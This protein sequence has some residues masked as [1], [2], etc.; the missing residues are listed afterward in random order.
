M[1]TLIIQYCKIVHIN[2][3]QALQ[4]VSIHRFLPGEMY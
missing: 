4:S 1:L 3:R 2:L